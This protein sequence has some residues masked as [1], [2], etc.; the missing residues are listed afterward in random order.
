M[1]I[2]AISEEAHCHK[3]PS[4]NADLQA[5]K[6][7]SEAVRVSIWSTEIE[8]KYKEKIAGCNLVVFFFK[9]FLHLPLLPSANRTLFE[10]HSNTHFSLNQCFH[11]C[12]CRL[13]SLVRTGNKEQKM[14][15]NQTQNATM[16][17]WGDREKDTKELEYRVVNMRRARP[18]RS[19]IVD[20]WGKENGT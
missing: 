15:D 2:E 20:A 1:Y 18:S 8:L 3:L 19:K 4:S 7:E 12:S 17:K 10:A 14:E 11:P 5:Q 13:V 16:R 9:M 6:L